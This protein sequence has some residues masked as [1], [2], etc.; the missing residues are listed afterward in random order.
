M[1]HRAQAKVVEGG[2]PD[3]DVRIGENCLELSAATPEELAVLRTWV[4][5]V[6]SPRFAQPFLVEVPPGHFH[7]YVG[8][9]AE[10]VRT[11]R[12]IQ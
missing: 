8:E 10:R 6:N 7:L 9:A 1:R 3:H 2:V 12:G 4:R 5:R 11:T